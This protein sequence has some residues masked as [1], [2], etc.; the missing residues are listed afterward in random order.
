[1]MTGHSGNTRTTP[2]C[3]PFET[4]PMLR[5]T[6]KSAFARRRRLALTVVAVMLGVGMVTATLTVALALDEAVDSMVEDLPA[7]ADIV[8]RAASDETGAAPVVTDAVIERV[9]RLPGVLRADGVVVGYAQL[10]GEDGT[11]RPSPDLDQPPQGSSVG[12]AQ[13]EALVAGRLPVADGE[14]VIDAVTATDETRTIGDTVQVVGADGAP[15]EFAV[16]G[17]LDIPQ[18]RGAPRVGFDLATARIVL[19]RPAGEFDSLDIDAVADADPEALAGEVAAVV[20][21]DAEVLTTADLA[22][23]H[24]AEA[25]TDVGLFAGLLVAFGAVALVIGALIIRNTFTIVVGQRTRE[26]A[27]LRALGAD[28]RQVRRSVLVEAALVGVAGSVLGIILGI[29]AAR[30][31]WIVMETFDAFGSLPAPS[32]APAP[33]VVT[34]AGAVGLVVAVWSALAPARRASQV[35]PVAAMR[36]EAVEHD[37]GRARKGV[38]GTV[39][40]LAAATMVVVGVTGSSGGLVAG[41]ALLTLVGLQVLGPTVAGPAARFVGRPIAAGLGWTGRL[42]R[43]NAARSPRRTAATAMTLLI[44][45]ALTA[46]LG[47]WATSQK[48]TAHVRFDEA[49]TADYRL[50]VPGTGFSGPIAPE[51]TTSLAALPQVGA[52]SAFHSPTPDGVSASDPAGLPEL[53]EDDVVAGDLSRL[54]EG[55]VAISAG[56]ADERGWE[57]GDRVTLRVSDT[58]AQF[59]VAAVFDSAMLGPELLIEYAG[60][61]SRGDEITALLTPDDYVALGGDP[62]L[63]WIYALAA[64]GVDLDEA[65]AAIEAAI[66]DHPTVQLHDR[67]ELRVAGDARVDVGV[68]VFYGLIGL[69]VVISLFGIVNTLAL[70]IAERVREIGLLRAIGMTRGGVRAMVSAEAVVI[71]AL[72]ASVGIVLGVVFCWAMF[73]TATPGSD[74]DLILTV[75]VLQLVAV[76]ALSVVVG[77]TA[78]VPPSIR[79][80]RVDISRALTTE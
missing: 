27:L 33:W 40:V 21:P 24:A 52:L 62:N 49:F 57:I 22:A 31:L 54:A 75:P 19:D 58:P 65:T 32:L 70:S 29:V 17:V 68:R 42:A 55:M 12:W 77:I 56:L 4:A 28:R 48:E 26:L 67:E 11:P 2:P 23:E 39:L 38:L 37:Q 35:A 16:V 51:V 78:A 34:V 36:A 43:E 15:V 76:A 72:G 44:G 30:G 71:A 64:E 61:A 3:T 1:M 59:T 25:G 73:D 41:G 60:N 45:V 7:G 63:G 79:A 50:D 80:A 10:I 46:F 6:F 8:V 69:L 74:L 20:G 13:E 53:L 66:A 14:A 5:Q 47:V 9:R 18:L